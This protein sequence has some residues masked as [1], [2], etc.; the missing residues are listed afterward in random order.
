[1]E[2][3]NMFAKYIIDID[4]ILAFFDNLAP[5]LKKHNNFFGGC[6]FLAKNLSNFVSLFLLLR[7]YTISTRSPI[8]TKTCRA[9]K[10]K[11]YGLWFC[12]SPLLS[13]RIIGRDH[14]KY[15][16]WNGSTIKISYWAD[17]ARPTAGIKNSPKNLCRQVIFIVFLKL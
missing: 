10:S 15:R 8:S 7:M 9:C 2:K 13:L 12:A 4:Q 14:G 3:K 11:F 6:W 16:G 17:L 5:L 1:M